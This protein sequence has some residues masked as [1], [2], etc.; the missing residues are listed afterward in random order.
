MGSLHSQHGAF[1][2]TVLARS[3]EHETMTAPEINALTLSYTPGSLS[4]SLALYYLS[5]SLVC[6][7]AMVVSIYASVVEHE[8]A[9]E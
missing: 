6:T 3:Q 5:S 4:L 2:G 1:Y 7:Y 8:T 9:M